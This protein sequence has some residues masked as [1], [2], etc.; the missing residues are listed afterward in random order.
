MTETA[1]EAVNQVMLSLGIDVTDPIATQEQFHSMRQV[2]ALL[3]DPELK[4]DLAAIRQWRE[5][6]DAIKKAGLFALVGA[7]VT[8]V[9]TFFGWAIRSAAL[10]W[11]THHATKPPGP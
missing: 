4:K 6:Q 10:D 2:V 8:L 1:R 9:I 3:A 5:A 7:L 11:L